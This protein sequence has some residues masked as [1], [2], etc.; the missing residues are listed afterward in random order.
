MRQFSFKVSLLLFSTPSLQR[1]N[2][3]Y[4]FST[5]KS[6]LIQYFVPPEPPSAVITALSLLGQVSTGFAH[7]GSVSFPILL[8]RYS[9]TVQMDEQH[10]NCSHRSWTGLKCRLLAG[11]LKDHHSPEAM[12]RNSPDESFCPCC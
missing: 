3:Q 4:S 9:Q 5:Y 7:L 1:S 11:P 2:L 12:P 6:A 8:A 10:L